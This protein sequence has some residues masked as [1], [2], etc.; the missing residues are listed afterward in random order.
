M[1]TSE[2]CILKDRATKLW[3][4]CQHIDLSD[5]LIELLI[6]A[7][8]HRFR[9]HLGVDMIS[10]T[11]ALLRFVQ[12]KSVEGGSTIAMQLARVLT[13]HYERT[14]KRKILEITYAVRMTRL[15]GKNDIPKMYLMV[16]YYG[17]KMNGLKQAAERMNINVEQL[18]AQQAAEIIARLKYPEPRYPSEHRKNKINNRTRHIL[19]LRDQL[20]A[21]T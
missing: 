15:F 19:H 8:D 3:K 10:M 20:R 9:Q 13:G 14:I 4:E 6:V 5:E 11:R 16:A 1:P 18:N 2:W 12:R 7:E 17:W 21:N